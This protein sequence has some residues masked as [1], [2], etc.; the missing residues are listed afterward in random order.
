MNAATST[1]LYLDFEA[2]RAWFDRALAQLAASLTPDVESELDELNP[3]PEDDQS[4]VAP[5]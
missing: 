3:P 2:E 1:A 4:I 5:E